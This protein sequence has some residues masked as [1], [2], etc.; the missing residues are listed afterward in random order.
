[1]MIFKKAIPRRA[2]LRG[3]GATLAVPLLDGMVPAFGAT[4]AKPVV[5]MAF[6][7]GPNGRIMNKWTPATEGAAFEM[8]PTLEPLAPFRDRLLVLSGL[9]IKAAD[10]I[11]NEPGGVHARPC[12]AY[13]TGIHPKPGG[14]WGFRRTSLLR[15]NS[16]STPNWGRSSSP[17]TP[18]T[19]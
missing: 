6:I 19:L 11:G 18:P 3:V 5:R 13:L 2:F 16:A 7:Y 15:G 14:R 9:N 12:A 1:M 8:T 17:W 4:A 10:P